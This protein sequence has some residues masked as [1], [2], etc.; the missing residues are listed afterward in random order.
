MPRYVAL[1]PAAG[2]GSRFGNERPKQYMELL[3]KPML[4]HSIEVLARHPR[5]SAIS[6]VISPQDRW[7]QQFDWHTTGVKLQFHRVGGATRADSVLRGLNALD[8]SVSQD[9][10]VLVHDAARPCLSMALLDRLIEEVADDAIGGL[11]AV[12][13]A[14]TL[15]QA[16]DSN[17]VSATRD[18]EGMWG[19]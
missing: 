5:I 18:R 9:D 11:L 14:D 7:F 8:G 17:R 13:V 16:D 3:G 4:A 15:K 6:V 12:R 1:I 10:W 19:A 2:A